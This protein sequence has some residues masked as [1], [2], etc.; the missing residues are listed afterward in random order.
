MP[1]WQGCFHPVIRLGE[2]SV[3]LLLLS[4]FMLHAHARSRLL[5]LH[6]VNHGRLTSFVHW[7][8]AAGRCK[9]EI[10]H[11][12]EATLVALVPRMRIKQ[13][14]C[15]VQYS[16]LRGS[17]P[18]FPIPSFSYWPLLPQTRHARYMHIQ[19]ISRTLPSNITSPLPRPRPCSAF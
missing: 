9:P 8:R 10:L 14:T 16:M 13:T 3:L 5:P 12:S 2:T 4:M 18:L 1:C 7:P 11:Q 15:I 6:G 17:A 19:L